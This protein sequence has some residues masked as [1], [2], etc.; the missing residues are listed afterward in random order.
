MSDMSQGPQ[1][2]ATR[3]KHPTDVHA[4]ALAIN[5]AGRHYGTVAEIGAGQE[6]AR[7]FLRVGAASGTVAQTISAHD[8][9]F[10]DVTYGSGTRYVSRERLLAML[11]YEYDLLE[12][13]L[14][15][16]RG[17]GTGFFVFADI[18]ARNFT[19]DNEQHGWLGI[20][21]QDQPGRKTSDVLIH[22]NLMDPSA[23]LQ[24]E[25]IGL[26]GVNLIYA[27]YYQRASSWDGF[28]SGLFD[29][30]SIARMEVDVIELSGPSFANTDARLV[31]L[32]A[33]RCGM[34][35]A[36]V[37]DS[38]G[39][40]TEPSSVL[41]K[42]P[43]IVERGRFETVNPYEPQMLGASDAELKRE[44]V[45]LGRD[46]AAVLEMTIKDAWGEAAPDDE[47]LLLR[48]VEQIC[49]LGTVIVSD[50]PLPFLLIDY[51]RRHT[52]EPIRLV[53]GVATLAQI[54][55]DRSY[56]ALAGGLLEGVGKLLAA[57]VKVY[58]YPEPADRFRQ[59]MAG[60]GDSAIAG[61][62][63]GKLV[64]ADDILPAPPADHFYRYLRAADWIR[65]LSP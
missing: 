26:L 4:K 3:A 13:R 12:K 16:T 37:F 30:L 43:L 38:S 40:V 28:L 65:P 55:H 39:K 58:A 45:L 41:R 62:S 49:T 17:A 29:E 47:S 34:T 51:L 61:Q 52:T 14:G 53:V 44:G 42:R 35:H 23:Q 18:A 27:A 19:G 25:A 9:T 2:A 64:S 56:G 6:V 57:N 21:F 54:L 22:V 32:Q 46:P 8:K 7:W 36:V 1:S 59:A 20:R 31:C 60:M 33:L 50:F 5:L 24:Q 48:R 11:E 63:A 10:S 15:S